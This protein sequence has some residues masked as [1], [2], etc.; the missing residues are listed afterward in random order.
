MCVEGEDQLVAV[1]LAFVALYGELLELWNA[2][3]DSACLRIPQAPAE[4][5]AAV[6][7]S[8]RAPACGALSA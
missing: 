1:A 4:R 2:G 6:R 7:V 5:W 8:R 3:V